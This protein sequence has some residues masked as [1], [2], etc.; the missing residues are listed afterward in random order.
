[1]SEPRWFTVTG[2]ERDPNAQIGSH[3]T[4]EAAADQ[5][6][7]QSIYVGWAIPVHTDAGVR[8]G[9]G[10]DGRWRERKDWRHEHAMQHEAA[11]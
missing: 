3:D 1:M 10:K 7:R 9:S 8:V 5:A 4:L 2:T 11:T 6:A